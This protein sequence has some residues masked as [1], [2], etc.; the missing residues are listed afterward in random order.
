MQDLLS[1]DLKDMEEEVLTHVELL[2]TQAI[3]AAQQQGAEAPGVSPVSIEREPSGAATKVTA[4]PSP[5]V[6]PVASAAAPQLMPTPAAQD[7]LTAPAA[8]NGPA[9]HPPASGSHPAA[10][11]R[12]TAQSA[13]DTLS[14]DGASGNP[15][16]ANHSFQA[17][18]NAHGEQNGGVQPEAAAPP[19]EPT[20]STHANHQQGEVQAQSNPPPPS[21]STRTPSAQQTPSAQPLPQSTGTAE[22]Q[23]KERVGGQQANQQAKTKGELE[24]WFNVEKNNIEEDAQESREA[25][26]AEHERKLAEIEATKQKDLQTLQA[27]FQK[28]LAK[29]EAATAQQ[30][31]AAG[32]PP[33]TSTPVVAPQ[34]PAQVAPLVVDAPQEEVQVV[35]PVQGSSGVFKPA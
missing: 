15:L 19:P 25:A 23:S 3:K 16:S 32:V 27:K 22:Q 21:T 34:S 9:A 4:N 7:P 12:S 29:L 6:L 18:S 11:T 24:A 2:F 20:S 26:I 8:S 1:K 30:P 33:Q 28:R 35:A 5:T 17:A 31:P 13:S 14:S 10:T